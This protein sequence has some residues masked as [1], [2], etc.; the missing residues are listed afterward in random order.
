[1]NANAIMSCEFHPLQ[2][3]ENTEDT[4]LKKTVKTGSVKILCS[5]TGFLKQ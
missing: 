4:W 1:M 5:G 2:Q 3:R